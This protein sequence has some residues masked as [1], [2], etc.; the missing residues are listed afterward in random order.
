LT[1]IT[2]SYS[3]DLSVEHAIKSRDII[4]S[5]KFKRLFPETVIRRDKGGKEH[6]EYTGKGA[7]VTTSTGSAITGFHANVIISDDPLNPTQSASDADRKTANEH[8]KTL[9][10]RKRDKANTPTILVMQR[11]HEEDVTGYLLKKKGNKIKHI[12]LPAELSKLVSPEELKDKY[13]DGLLDPIRIGQEVIAEAKVDLG[14]D[15][16]AKQF[17]QAPTSEEG[18]IVKKEWFQRISRTTFDGLY[19]N[20]PIN[21]FVDT[22]FSEKNKKTDNDPSGIIATKFIRNNLYIFKAKKVHMNAPEFLKFLVDWTKENGYQW[23]SSIR[24]EPKANGKTI[25]QLLQSGT[26]LS[27]VESESP[28]DD[29]ITRLRGYSNKIEAGK[30]YLVDDSWTDDFIEEVCGFP[31]KS[32][33]EYVDTLSEALR[34]YYSDESTEYE[35]IKNLFG[36]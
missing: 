27:V 34:Y 8:T 3:S 6:Y 16:Y 18:N 30:V 22:A 28:K 31:F 35:N 26:K 29:K 9:S 15:G 33:D 1:V 14:S 17:E 2:N 12:C 5:P 7:R 36:L 11:L 4:Q 32:H 23:D 10:S 13:I 24:I 25:V 20:E 21:F 19:S